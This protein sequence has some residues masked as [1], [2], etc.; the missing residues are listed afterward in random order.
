MADA[1]K[2][3][4]AKAAKYEPPKELEPKA[5][6][7]KFMGRPK[8]Q[9]AEQA[10]YFYNVKATHIVFFVSS[11]LMLAGLVAMFWK[12]YDRPWKPYQQAF[13]D[14]EFE[15]LWYEMSALRKAE[16]AAR[17]E[18]GALESQ[19]K[20]F[21]SAFK[22]TAPGKKGKAVPVTIFDKDARTRL[23]S[24]PEVVHVAVDLEKKKLSIVEKEEMRGQRYDRTLLYNF[25]KDKSGAVRSQF[26]A[27][28]HHY[29]HAQKTRERIPVHEHHYLH[30]KEEWEKIKAD[31]ER[32]KVDY[33][34]AEARNGFYE[35]FAADL[36]R[37]KVAGVWELEPL[38][39]I[40]DRL[41]KIRKELDEKL[42][43]FEKDRPNLA[44]AVRDKPMS[45]FFAPRLKVQQVILEDL[46]DQL[47][48]ARVDKVDRCHTCHVAIDNPTYAVHVDPKAKDELGKYV[49]KEPFLRLFVDHAR[50]YRGEAKLE[51]KDCEVCD[52]KGRQGK[53]IPKPLTAHGAW[54]S[55]EAIKFTKAF[56]AHPRLDLFAADSSKHPRARFGCTVCHEGDGRDTDFTRVVHIADSP[57]EAAD[58]R[59]RHGTPYGEEHYNWNY[60]E[61]WDLPMIASKF[62]QSSCRRCHTDAVELDGGE[63][64]VK[65]MQLLER[66]GCYGCH[67]IDTY[68]ILPKDVEN[69]AIDIN[70]KNRRPGPP[71]TRIATKIDA[72]TAAK[73]ILEP[74][75][76]REST[77]MPH[78]F[79]Q[80]NLRHEVNRHPAPPREGRS[81][82]DDTIVA[83]IVDY[84]WE[85]SET[86][87]DEAPA[88]KGDAKRGE[89]LFKQAGCIA[90]HKAKE[91]PA[92][93]FSK[94]E[95]RSRY[96]EEFGPNL[97]S[98]GSKLGT[99]AGKTWLWHWLRNPKK[100][101]P[102]SQMASLRLGEQEAA[103]VVEYL[104]T[105][106]KPAWEALPAPKADPKVVDALISELLKKS[107][108]D[109]A[110]RI[111][112]EGKHH[113]YGELKDEAG[114]R[115]WLGRRMVANFGCYSCHALKSDPENGYEWGKLEG[116]GVELTGAQPFGVKHWDRLD[117]G[118][119]ADDGV[120]HHGITFKH[121]FSGETIASRVPETRPDWLAAKLQNPRVF[122]GGKME[123]K[124]WDELLRMPNFAL[125][126][127]EIEQ[128]QTFVLSFTDHEVTKLVDGAKKRPTPDDI[129][130]Y[131]GDRI[132]REN[133]CRACHRFS[134][135]RFEV[136]WDRTEEGKPKTT[137]ET[138]EGRNLGRMQ[139][140]D[141]ERVL[142]AW[143]IKGDPKALEVYSVDWSVDPHSL[144]PTPLVKEADKFVLFDGREWSYLTADDAGG[145]IRR[146]VRRHF[147]MDG[148]EVLPVILETKK[149]LNREY[150][151]LKEKLET[152]LEELEDK[153]KA[154]P[155]NQKPA[156][157]EQRKALDARI[158]RDFAADNLI[159][160]DDGEYEARYP[161]MLRTQGHKTQA[162]WL[163]KFLKEP[164]PIRPNIFP[165][166][167]G[168][169][170]MPD[171]NIRMPS[172]GLTD[173]EAGA[174]VRWFW[175]RDRVPNYP[176]T[177][178]P[179]RGEAF[180]ASRKPVHEKVMSSVIREGTKGCASCHW[181]GAQAPP[182]DPF[183]HAPDLA[184]IEER[185]RP[186]WLY[187]W[188]TKPSALYPRTTMTQFWQNPAD[189]TQQDE[190]RAAVEILLNF[191]RLT[192]P[193]R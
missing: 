10:E 186:Q 120:N 27:A 177:G 169:K 45:D 96:L 86:K 190:I 95:D 7:Q 132:I 70:R 136:R 153:I 166:A 47:N 168:A 98:I 72:P 124:P 130:R 89:L 156:L 5:A 162:D 30:W 31:V 21:L 141:A 174:V 108:S 121:G 24:L 55:D 67:R 11:L 79:K 170:T 35:D 19:E 181:I 192:S 66:L 165:V 134:L 189:P 161:P 51:A 74:R 106:R 82:V 111:A 60:R 13:L 105:L 99:P 145:R 157:E 154:A 28:T 62:V 193:S 68:Q 114:K 91:V 25:A 92:A 110:A 101:F 75:E 22:E 80:S 135:D 9:P 128:I 63:K 179:E 26:E 126:P 94:W 1:A 6:V 103:D 102:E 160:N 90:C 125:T 77:R 61:L 39:T 2:P 23:P 78:F 138:V 88:A 57:Q 15:K 133:N 46:K 34:D 178:F 146:P 40:Q 163:F 100:H 76:F 122:D 139:P 109:A 116:I 18:I 164:Y 87:G 180:L 38:E 140:D 12:D 52:E 119:T 184:R 123:S 56:M 104:V 131:R 44:N 191:R 43:R 33:D 159:K 49:F 115:R 65:G 36:M 84:L 148:G 83:C 69:A 167:P 117:F 58:W 17:N 155:A 144:Q 8:R 173:E 37:R 171:T 137:F 118:F 185:L 73:W 59:R 42:V 150:V 113:L 175:V 97:S 112:V 182:G 152:E 107:L 81:P 149:Q 48:F 151:A 3:D 188:V 16:A 176:H 32:K 158:G 64:Y 172:F 71:L 20:A 147:P 4:A 29:E 85:R 143:G 183:K 53:E 14:L 50:G 187:P 41:K 93:E 54:G 127:Y 129:A 142:T